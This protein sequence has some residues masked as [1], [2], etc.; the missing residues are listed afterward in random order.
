MLIAES[1]ILDGKKRRKEKKKKEKRKKKSENADPSSGEVT[2]QGSV[3][4]P[5]AVKPVQRWAWA[6]GRRT[7][8]PKREPGMQ[9]RVVSSRRQAA[10]VEGLRVGIV[11]ERLK[12]ARGRSHAVQKILWSTLDN[13]NEFVESQVLHL[14]RRR[15]TV[16][17]S[18]L[19][20]E[21]VAAKH[22]IYFP[23][24]DIC[25]SLEDLSDDFSIANVEVAAY[26]M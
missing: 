17:T 16:N 4:L 5:S 3:L 26:V 14:S 19:G 2:F 22:G 18:S 6:E 7:V 15:M 12:L 13:S 9:H 21:C 1:L 23:R 10:L 11:R 20:G 24:V 8:R 25:F